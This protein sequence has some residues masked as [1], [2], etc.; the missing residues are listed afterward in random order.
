MK[1]AVTRFVLVKGDANT[2]IDTI[3]NAMR[4][5]LASTIVRGCEAVDEKLA[6]WLRRRVAKQQTRIE[7]HAYPS[8]QKASRGG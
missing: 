5:V 3:R 7:R 2:M 4:V 6:R 8:V 1:D